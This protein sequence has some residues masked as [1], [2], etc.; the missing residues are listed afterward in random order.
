MTQGLVQIYTGNGKG[1]TTAAGGLMLRALG[2]GWKVLLVRF[3]KTPESAGEVPLLKKLG[4]EVVESTR[5]G[6]VDAADRLALQADV[7]KTLAQARLAL[8]DAYDLV[9]LDEF[10]GLV[11]SGFISLD[12]AL[13]LVAQRPPTT[14]LVL[15]GRHAPDELIALADLVTRMEPVAHPY[16]RGICAR[17]GIEY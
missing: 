9:V 6:I 8:S 15:T 12:H 2:H 3:L 1:K 16:T 4:V 11:H 7:Q 13:T 17:K 5:G 14:E 10:N